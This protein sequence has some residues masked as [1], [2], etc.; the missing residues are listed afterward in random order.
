MIELRFV[1]PLT[2]GDQTFNHARLVA[3]GLQAADKPGAGVRQ[4]LVVEIDRVLRRQHD[5][6]AERARL[7]QQR[8][9]RM[10]R[11]RIAT[12]GK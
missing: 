3:L 12:G 7:L 8:E 2:C 1:E 10:L 4:S 6:E 9:Q 5:A 11:R